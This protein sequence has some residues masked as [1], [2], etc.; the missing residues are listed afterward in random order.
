MAERRWQ[1]WRPGET[2]KL[3]GVDPVVGH[4]GAKTYAPENTLVSIRR[5]RELGCRWVEL[6]VKLSRDGVPVLIH[7]ERLERTTNGRG[8]VKDFGF[9]E[10]RGLDAG[11]WKGAEFAGTPI[12][13]LAE[14]LGLLVELDMD[15]NLEIKPCPGREAETAAV[16]CAEIRRRW[17]EGRPFPLLSSFALASLEAA[18]DKAPELPRG[19]LVEAIPPD[20]RQTMQRLDC[21]ALHVGHRY[22]SDWA[23]AAVARE[24]VP[25]LVYTV[26]DP[27][28]A[29]GLFEL[30]AA[31]VFSDSPDL[32]WPV[33]Q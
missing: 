23:M 20:W 17:P 18:Q 11:G 29:R 3:E 19:Y 10:L 21:V 7:D 5:A 9:E 28:R 30:G 33:V 13:T 26:N 16:A 4:R 24:G 6:D 15:L 25:L 32:I 22:N 12:P 2:C 1:P 8:E 27:E 31:A 14:A